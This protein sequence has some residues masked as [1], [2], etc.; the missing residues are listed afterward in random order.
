MKRYK[1]TVNEYMGEQAD[2]PLTD[3]TVKLFRE[4]GDMRLIEDFIIF[5]PTALRGTIWI[6]EPGQNPCLNSE[7]LKMTI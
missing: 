6:S 3:D 2:I 7:K 1:L 5:L 4:L